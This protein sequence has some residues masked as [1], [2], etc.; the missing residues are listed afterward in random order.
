LQLEL[1]LAMAD[2]PSAT[3]FGYEENKMYSKRESELIQKYLQERGK[4]PG[5]VED[6]LV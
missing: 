1:L 3:R 4:M 6:D 2:F 5:G